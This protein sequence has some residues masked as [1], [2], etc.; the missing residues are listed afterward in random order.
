MSAGW[1]GERFRLSLQYAD[2]PFVD[3]H[4]FE[5]RVFLQIEDTHEVSAENDFYSVGGLEKFSFLPFILRK[6]TCRYRLAPQLYAWLLAPD[7]V[8]VYH[9]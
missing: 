5:M 2:L 6:Y 9:F 4:Y 8:T 7:A 3:P 1:S